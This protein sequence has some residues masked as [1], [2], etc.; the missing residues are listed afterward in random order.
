MLCVVCLISCLLLSACSN[1]NPL[2]PPSYRSYEKENEENQDGYIEDIDK[3]LEENEVLTNKNANNYSERFKSKTNSI[4]YN[5]LDNY[6]NNGREKEEGETFIQSLLIS[7]YSTYN[8]IRL[9][10]PVIFI[11]SIVFGVIGMLFSR[12]NKGAKRFFLVAFIIAIPVL[13]LFI[14]FG[15]GILN[16]I[17]I[18]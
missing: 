5:A 9:V 14:V 15:I 18:Y 12:Y 8:S 17:F 16:S 2:A 13:L 4:Y 1:M 3:M 10:S 7:F 6:A 11:V